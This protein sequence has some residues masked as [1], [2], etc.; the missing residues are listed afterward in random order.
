MNR[1]SNKPLMSSVNVDRWHSVTLTKAPKAIAAWYIGKVSREQCTVGRSGV[2]MRP[3]VI[4]WVA[5]KGRIS[6]RSLADVEWDAVPSTR[7]L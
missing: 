7:L 2:F 3:G 1:L 6:H 5:V 4:A